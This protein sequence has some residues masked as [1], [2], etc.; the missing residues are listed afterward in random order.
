MTL[1]DEMNERR[2]MIVCAECVDMFVSLR[3]LPANIL[4]ALR[5]R[6]TSAHAVYALLPEDTDEGYYDLAIEMTTISHTLGY[7]RRVLFSS[8]RFWFWTL[9]ISTSKTLEVGS[10]GAARCTSGDVCA[11]GKL[12]R[13]EVSKH[14]ARKAHCTA[15]AGDH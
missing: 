11:S 4:E 9:D 5:S 8:L 15:L 7:D 13:H 3:T 12:S 10:A 6:T 14:V 1:H 2:R